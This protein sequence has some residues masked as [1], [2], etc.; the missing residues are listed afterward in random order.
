MLDY[1]RTIR[2]N[3]AQQTSREEMAKSMQDIATATVEAADNALSQLKDSDEL[4]DEAAIAKLH[5]P[6]T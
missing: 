4:F 3:A 1:I 6:A 5:N 2:Q